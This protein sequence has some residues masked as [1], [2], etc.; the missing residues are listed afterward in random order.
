MKIR[1]HQELEVYQMA[2]DAAMRIFQLT[3]SFPKEE[4]YSL[5]DQIRRSSRSVCAN[6]GEAW[7]K[8]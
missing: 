5:V 4:R 6:I 1:T 7:R 8:R 3:K 2:F